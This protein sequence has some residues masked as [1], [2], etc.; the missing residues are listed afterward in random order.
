MV[1]YRG[2]LDAFYCGASSFNVSFAGN[3]AVALLFSTR[4]RNEDSSRQLGVVGELLKGF[5]CKVVCRKPGS[6]KPSPIDRVD[7]E[8][9]IPTTT[10]TTTTT[11][12]APPA[13]REEDVKDN[14]RP[15][16][17]GGA[18]KPYPTGPSC[19]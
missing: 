12:Q 10:T 9:E 17:P 15:S 18:F 4:K 11:P 16:R 1:G 3:D 14:K 13:K 5:G 6:T 7:Q 19:K 2:T 8:E